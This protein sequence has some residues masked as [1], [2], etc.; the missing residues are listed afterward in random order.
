MV[1]RTRLI[2]TLYLHKGHHFIY[3]WISVGAKLAEGEIVTLE[4]HLDPASTLGKRSHLY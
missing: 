1:T 3:V 2:I 4:I